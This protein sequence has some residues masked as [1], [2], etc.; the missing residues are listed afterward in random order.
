MPFQAYKGVRVCALGSISIKVVPISLCRY[1]SPVRG[2][3]SKF[4]VSNKVWQ[5]VIRVGTVTSRMASFGTPGLVR[6]A[7]IDIV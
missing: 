2:S 6:R 5:I 7:E 4:R 1:E 3:G